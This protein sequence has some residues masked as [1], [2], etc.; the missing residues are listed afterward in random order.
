MC[1]GDSSF[2]K[3]VFKSFAHSFT[4]MFSV[5]LLIHRHFYMFSILAPHIANIFFSAYGLRFHN[6]YGLF[7][8]T[9]VI[10]FSMTKSIIL[11]LYSLYFSLTQ[12]IFIYSKVMNIFSYI[13][14]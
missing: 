11:L 4:G 1:F 13:I 8:W 3:Y 9:E 12:K 7:R 2:V 6:F 14:I 5:F 10:N